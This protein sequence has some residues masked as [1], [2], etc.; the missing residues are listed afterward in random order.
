MP[1]AEDSQGMFRSWPE[2][3][4]A[5]A[6]CIGKAGD[7]PGAEKPGEADPPAFGG[8]HKMLLFG[9]TGFVALLLSRWTFRRRCMPTQGNLPQ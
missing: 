1:A 2:P 4:A 5:D 3:G 7:E 9:V 8:G 6:G